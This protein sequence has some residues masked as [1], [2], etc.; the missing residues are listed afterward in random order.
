MS[1]VVGR[2]VVG[3]MQ[4]LW[5]P[6]AGRV[7]AARWGR[8]VLAILGMRRFCDGYQLLGMGMT[9]LICAYCIVHG[10]YVAVH[11]PLELLHVERHVLVSDVARGR[12]GG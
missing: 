7:L 3:R 1:L 6:L 9:M 5:L 2:A 4:G 11:L 12:R 8:L 10:Q